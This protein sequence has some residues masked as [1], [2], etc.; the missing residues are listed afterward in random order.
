MMRYVLIFDLYVKRKILQ[1]KEFL[2]LIDILGKRNLLWNFTKFIQ[3]CTK[4]TKD[5]SKNDQM[6]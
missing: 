5:K 2:E 3:F 1:N 6:N 4:S